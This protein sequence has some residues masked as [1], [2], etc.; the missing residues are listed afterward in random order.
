MPNLFGFFY[1]R[2]PG[3]M[4]AIVQRKALGCVKKILNTVIMGITIITMKRTP[5]TL[6]AHLLRKGLHPPAE[7]G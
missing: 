2:R 7:S 6:V 3:D 5:H 1:L 4:H